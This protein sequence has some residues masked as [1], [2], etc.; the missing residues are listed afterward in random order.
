MPYMNLTLSHA[1]IELILS[2]L[3]THQTALCETW[4]RVS[5]RGGHVQAAEIN[6]RMSRVDHIGALLREYARQAPTD[7][8]LLAALGPCGR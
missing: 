5:D 2:A 7:S 1:D 4:E 3:N 8:Q 6:S